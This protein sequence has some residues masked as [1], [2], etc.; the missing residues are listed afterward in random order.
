MYQ[1]FHESSSRDS[2]Y[3]QMAEATMS[4]FLYMFCATRCTEN[5][6]VARKAREF[7]SKV[8]MVVE[9]WKSPPKSKQPGGGKQCQTTNFEYLY[10][11]VKEVLAPL[12]LKFFK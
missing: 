2:D 10:T 7:W 9:C 4:D 1:R 8:A 5:Q 12:K 11:E 3:K 6:S